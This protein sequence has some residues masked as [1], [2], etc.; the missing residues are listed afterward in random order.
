MVGSLWKK[1]GKRFLAEIDVFVQTERLIAIQGKTLRSQSCANVV[2]YS[3]VLHVG[4]RVSSAI[5]V[6]NLVIM[7]DAVKVKLQMKYRKGQ[8]RMNRR[9]QKRSSLEHQ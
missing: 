4:P 1:S 3:M 5:N 9:V 6:V 7:Q 2:D 8:L